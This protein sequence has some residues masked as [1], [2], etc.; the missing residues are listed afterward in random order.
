MIDELRRLRE[1]CDPKSNQNPRY[2]RYSLAVTALR[3]LVNDLERENSR[4]AR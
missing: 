3:W 4:K 1:R 2:H